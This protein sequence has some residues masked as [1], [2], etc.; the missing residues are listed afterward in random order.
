MVTMK[1][2]EAERFLALS[3]EVLEHPVYDWQQQYYHHQSL[4]IYDHSLV[5]AFLAWRIAKTLGLSQKAVIRGG[6]LH[7][8]FLYDWH[9]EGRRN[10]KPLLKKHGFTHADEALLNAEFFFELNDMERDII[11]T[12]MFPLNI[13]PPAYLESILV[14]AV[15]TWVTFREFIAGK[16]GAPHPIIPFVR[17]NRKK[18]HRGG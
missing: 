10:P 9:V 3:E 8:F 12:H 2:T 5:V 1:K 16:S 11:A 4:T 13:R 18:K 17:E 14:N 7:D 6:L 15:D